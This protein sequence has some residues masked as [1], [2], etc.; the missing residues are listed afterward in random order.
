[1]CGQTTKT[2]S[3]S[4]KSI[5]PMCEFGYPLMCSLWPLSLMLERQRPLA[6]RIVNAPG[7]AHI[8][9]STGLI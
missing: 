4:E 9:L 3:Q 2:D 5:G 7:V 1:M 8:P 6:K